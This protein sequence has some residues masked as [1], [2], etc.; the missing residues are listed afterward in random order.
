MDQIK[1]DESAL[2]TAVWLHHNT[3]SLLSTIESKGFQSAETTQLL[4][5]IVEKAAAFTELLYR[6]S[7]NEIPASEVSVWASKHVAAGRRTPQFSFV[8]R[9]IGRMVHCRTTKPTPNGSSHA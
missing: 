6:T 5:K 4:L 9:L 3:A 1:A 2:S 8:R 7:G